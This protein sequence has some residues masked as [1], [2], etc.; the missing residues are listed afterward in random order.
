[1]SIMCDKCD[2]ITKKIE[3]FKAISARFADA[4]MTEGLA[5]A[6]AELEAQKV[7]LHAEQGRGR[8]T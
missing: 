7:A 4:Q 3:R 6:I 8:V 2:E 1:M 5:V